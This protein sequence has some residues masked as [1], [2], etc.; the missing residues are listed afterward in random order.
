MNG[1]AGGEGQRQGTTDIAVVVDGLDAD[2]AVLVAVV[3][4]A[5][6]A[7]ANVVGRGRNQRYEVVLGIRRGGD[8]GNGDQN[9]DSGESSS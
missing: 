8:H 6:E 7:L 5:H 2:L 1:L 4:D 3:D 9:P